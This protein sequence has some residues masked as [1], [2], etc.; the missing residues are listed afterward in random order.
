MKAIP[1]WLLPNVLSL[2]A[3]LI[4][5]AWQ[6]LLSEVTGTPLRTAA[7]VILFLTV[8]L[9]YIADRILD[10]RRPAS[11]QEPARHQFYRRYRQATTILA[12]V[13]LLIDGFLILSVLHPAVFRTGLVAFA[14]VSL[15]FVILH[16]TAVSFSKE[17]A[18]AGLFTAGTF[19]VA[20]TRSTEPIAYLLAP[21]ASFLLLCFANLVAIEVWEGG[22]LAF[23]RWYL[24]W[25][26][27]FALTNLLFFS[28]PWAYAISLSAGSLVAIYA[29]G[30]TLGPEVRRVLVDTVLLIPPLLFL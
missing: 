22:S 7:R 20:F 27:A 4:A 5:V 6:G 15:Y 17:L 12:T 23:G 9:I 18:V 8:W 2:D 28:G 1:F 16:G 10:A 3:P 11:T 26:P 30:D 13:I 29:V 25:V 19:L 14:G 24:W 21:A